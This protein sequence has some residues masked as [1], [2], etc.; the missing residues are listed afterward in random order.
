MRR[1]VLCLFAGLLGLAVSGCVEEI[2]PADS[3]VQV[4]LIL[5]GS[6]TAPEET[7]AVTTTVSTAPP[8]ADEAHGIDN[9]GVLIEHVPH[10]TQFTE[11]L[12]A[13]ESIAAVNLLRY[14][15]IDI[16]PDDFLDGFLPVADYPSL[17]EDGELHA[18][19]PWEYFIG[20]PQR[21]DAYGCYNGALVKAI[22]K[23]RK[24][25]AFAIDDA[26]LDELCHDYIDNGEPVII[27]ATINMAPSRPGHTWIMP[28]GESYTFISPE[29]AL[30]MVGYDDNF[31]YF[32]DSLQ[33]PEIA[34]YR[35]DAVEKAYDALYRQ[36]VAVD[37]TELSRVPEFWRIRETEEAA[38]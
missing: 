30:V 12:T 8:F 24:G 15:G 36:A 19:S 2:P 33:Y 31:Y 18:E 29:H 21:K 4:D 28:N 17:G 34:K 3:V 9:N 13:C 26:G 35:R 7:T 37:M 38:Q 22:N 1:A 25:L 5:P 23:I 20:D 27:W 11:Y 32:S 10:Q 16:T 14:Y 6:T